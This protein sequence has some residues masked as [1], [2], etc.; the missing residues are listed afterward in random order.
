[1]RTRSK[2]PLF[3]M[4]LI[5]MLLVFAVS[6]AVCLRVFAGAKQISEDSARLDA[7]VIQAQTAAEYWKT[8]HGDLEET[9]KDMGVLSEG[10]GFAVYDDE[11]ELHLDFTC[12]GP[13]ANII[14]LTGEK[15]IF[16]ISCEAVM[17]D[18]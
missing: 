7:A 16:S 13:V 18:G 12:E 3:L 5:I 8:N 4:E 10:N 14:V 2:T 15:E 9:A 11:N 17:I 6:A 1:M